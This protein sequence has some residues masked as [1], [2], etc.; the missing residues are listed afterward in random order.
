MFGDEDRFLNR[1]AKV[2]QSYPFLPLVNADV[3]R[4]QPVYVDNVAQAIVEQAVANPET[5]VRRHAFAL[6]V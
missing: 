6:T 3:A 4:V 5:M 2:S 1:I